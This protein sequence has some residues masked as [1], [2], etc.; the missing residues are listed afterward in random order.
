[1]D[2]AAPN[3][4][5]DSGPACEPLPSRRSLSFALAA[6]PFAWIVQLVAGYVLTSQS[7]LSAETEGAPTGIWA[8]P[9][10]LV[11]QAV[12][13]VVA[14]CGVLLAARMWRE[15]AR[16]HAPSTIDKGETRTHF[17]ALCGVVGGIAFSVSILFNVP[18]LF[19]V[20]LC[21]N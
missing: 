15:S 3:V 14:L 17:L 21:P 4:P 5:A 8:H 1:M 7:C 6:A 9:S 2:D 12:C 16:T 10:P 13:F 20:P 18:A 11:V 19:V